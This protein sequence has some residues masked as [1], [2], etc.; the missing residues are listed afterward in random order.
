M[1]LGVDVFRI[2]KMPNGIYKMPN[3][4]YKMA[5]PIYKMDKPS[6]PSAISASNVL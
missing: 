5:F 4:I 1:S 2:Y 6:T 3:G